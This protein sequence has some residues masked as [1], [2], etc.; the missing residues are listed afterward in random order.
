MLR[1][2]LASFLL[3][4]AAV[5][6]TNTSAATF[7]VDRTDIDSIDINPGDGNCA[8]STSP[9]LGQRCTL[10]AAIMEANALPGADII[11]VPFSAH[12]V[13]TITGRNEDAGATGDLDITDPLVISTPTASSP[14]L[15]PIID[16]NAIDRVIDVRPS[17]GDVALQNL[18]IKNGAANDATT[19]GG[20]GIRAYS[21]STP[22]TLSVVYCEIVGNVANFGGGIQVATNLGRSLQ[23]YASTLHGNVISNLGFTNIEG[24]AIKDSDSGP[25][26]GAGV[27]IQGSSIYANLA[28]SGC[29]G[30][31][32]AVS[33]KTPTT[34]ENSTFSD[35]QPTALYTYGTSTTLNHV[36]ITGSQTGFGFGGF[37][38]NH[39]SSISNT[40]IAQNTLHNCE[41]NGSYGYNHNYS[42]SSDGSCLLGAGGVGNLPNSDPLL[43]PLA[44]RHG[45][46]PV[47]DLSPGSPAIDHGDT[48]MSGSGGTCLGEDQDGA[49]RPLDGDGGGARCDMGAIEYDDWIFVNGFES[50]PG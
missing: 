16:A 5:A 28:E 3:L 15:R 35:N 38:V 34:I 47:H 7:T 9:P 11:I 30:D 6:P 42:L 24:S 29:C 26:A 23:I 45:D 44:L 39:F 33:L 43:K 27:F 12:I 25:A 49:W 14:A 36:T 2:L 4:L 13:L 1:I 40:V 46:T 37:S 31:H 8:W 10:R 20:G 18:V 50:P 22:S 21:N 19:N 32:A 48:L 17:A 41:F